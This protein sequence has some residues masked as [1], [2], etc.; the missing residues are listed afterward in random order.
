MTEHNEPPM[1]DLSTAKGI[2]DAFLNH[3]VTLASLKK[4]SDEE[5]ECLYLVAYGHLSEGRPA[6]ALD[7][8]M[9]LVTHNPWDERFQFAFGLAL[10]MLGQYEAAGQHYGQALILN[11]TDAGCALRIGECL[12]AQGAATEAEEAYRACIALS[13]RNSSWYLVRSH[14]EAGLERL[15]KTGGVA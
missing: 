1:L 9:L 14:A 4:I 13:W 15:T 5:L 12:E 10:Q 8:L 3:G 11:A 7:D 6:E 2:A